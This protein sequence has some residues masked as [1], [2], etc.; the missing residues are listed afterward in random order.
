MAC[1]AGPSLAPGGDRLLHKL[2]EWIVSLL[3][4]WADAAPAKTR[5]E[6]TWVLAVVATL[7]AFTA[8]LVHTTNGTANPFLHLAYLPVI[9][10]SLSLGP[11]GGFVTALAAGLLV[12]GP[13]MPMDVQLGLSQ[14][15]PNVLYRTFFLVVVGLLVGA[16]GEGLRRRRSRIERTQARLDTLYGR[17]LRLFARLVSERDKE[18]S[19]HCERVAHNCVVVGRAMNLHGNTL[20][21]LYWSGLLHDLG[22][23][24][25]PEAILQKPGKLTTEEFEEVKR[26]AALGAELLLSVSQDFGPLASTIRSHH[27][28]WDGRG[29]PDGLM[30]E[31]IP[32]LARILAVVDVFEAVTS[33]RPYHRPLS[34]VEAR[35]LIR[36]GLGTHFDP[37]IATLFLHEEAAGRILHQTEPDPL[38]DSFV[39]VLATETDAK[40]GTLTHVDF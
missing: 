13:L 6:A 26:H 35:D 37:R 14:T 4:R 22:K 31:E 23:L 25:V 33:A 36:D 11:L 29:Y 8:A 15:L 1:R 32:L 9:I 39:N 20:K 38:Y 27:E 40:L 28:R 7:L 17:S 34:L 5:G 24:G 19:G 2:N 18:T 12:L 30:G 16:F 10:A 21:L 3:E